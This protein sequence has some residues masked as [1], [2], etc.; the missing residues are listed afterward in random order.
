[1]SW[2]KLAVTTALTEAM[3]TAV[4]ITGST[5]LTGGDINRAARLETSQGPLFLK[6]NDRPLAGFFSG[7]AAGLKALANSGTRLI[8]PQVIAWS[9]PTPSAP[10]FLA[11]T[12]LEPGPRARDFDHALGQGL[13]EL[14]RAT[15]S[16]FGFDLDNY[17]GTTPQPNPDETSWIS[18]YAEHRIAHQ[19]RLARDRGR[20]SAAEAAA[21][22]RLCDQ[23]GRWLTEGRPALIHGDL[24]SGNLHA[25]SGQPALIDPAA[26]YGHPEAELG[27]MTLFGGFSATTYAAYAEASGLDDDWRQRSALYELYHL[28]NHANLFG[29][30]YAAQSMRIVRH[31]T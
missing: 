21:C 30:G 29:G 16:G 10:G 28:L 8:I 22:D 14:H 9:D 15:R 20:L 17:I 7:E 6:W 5:P 3:G 31:Y 11:T 2:P 4:R 13:A 24:W 12:F 23:L 26:Y 19:A 25:H 18:F 1:M 27:M